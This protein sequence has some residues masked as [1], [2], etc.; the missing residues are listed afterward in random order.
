MERE[1][2]EASIGALSAALEH[3][4]PLP[5]PIYAMLYPILAAVLS[6]PQPSDLHEAALEAVALHVDPDVPGLPRTATL[7]LLF[8]V[9]ETMPGYRHARATLH[10]YFLSALSAYSLS[11]LS[12]PGSPATTGI[13]L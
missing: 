3:G 7:A 5:M 4:Q 10:A 12:A 1:P 13:L 2:V 11:A 9:L 6:W 8:H